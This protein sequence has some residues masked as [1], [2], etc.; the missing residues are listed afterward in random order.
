[1]TILKV[2]VLIFFLAGCYGCKKPLAE[3]P[4][5]P[6]TPPENRGGLL[7]IWAQ[8]IDFTNCD[9]TIV[10]GDSWSDY[11][12]TSNNY[13]K[14][15]A[16]SSAQR[17]INTA[18]IGLGSANMIAKA[19][20]KMDPVHNNTN[21][22]ALCGFNDVRFRGATHE[23]INFQK[24]AYRTLLVNQFIDT[25]R[26]AGQPNR[27]GGT[28]ISF[29]YKLSPHF[30][31]Y[32]SENKKAVYTSSVNDVFLEYDFKGTH[33]GVSFIGQDT[34]ATGLYHVPHGRWRVLIDGVVVDTPAIHQQAQGHIL[35]SMAPQAIFPYIRIYS[36]LPDGNHV[37]RLE[38]IGSGLKFVD[39]IFTLRDAAG[40]SPVTILKVPY[41]TNQGYSMQAPN[42]NKANDAAIDN[43]NKAINEVRNEFISIDARYAKKIKL[44]N[45]CDYFDR[46]KDY[47]PD[48][49]HPNTTG[50]LNLFRA[51]KANIVY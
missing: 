15:F 37:L 31:S 8:K 20:E 24:N 25:W 4:G 12:L 3:T 50:K 49:I 26:P 9:T 40:V 10:F 22:I 17:I 33:I 13:I 39:F 27:T 48:L 47:L 21:I 46:T 18:A 6:A 45:T 1:M 43:V 16:D 32:Y 29:D 34:T 11:R 44:I 19:F 14:M 41:M 23:L 36:G 35:P 30:K 51:L 5:P 38:P 7:D 42:F 2:F 28:F